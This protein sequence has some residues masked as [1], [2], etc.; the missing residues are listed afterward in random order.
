MEEIIINID[1]L[2]KVLARINFVNTVLDFKWRF[3]VEPVEVHQ[4]SQVKKGWFLWAEF[5]RPDTNTRNIG[6]ERGRDE[7]IWEGTTDSGAIKTA[8]MVVKMLIKH[9]LM[10]SF[11]VDGHRPFNLHHT[12]EAFNSLSPSLVNTYS[13]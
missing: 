1:Q 9:E 13:L 7:I 6:I 2:K 8:W 4:N 3:C 5:E 12:I 10:E 11:Q